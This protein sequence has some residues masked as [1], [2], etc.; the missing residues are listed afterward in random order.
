MKTIAVIGLIFFLLF[1]GAAF[2][3]HAMDEDIVPRKFS[4]V[5]LPC[6]ESNAA[7]LTNEN[8]VNVGSKQ[9]ATFPCLPLM[10]GAKV[11]RKLSYLDIWLHIPDGR[12]KQALAVEVD[13]KL[14]TSRLTGEKMT[15]LNPTI[16]FSLK[17]GPLSAEGSLITYFCSQPQSS[18]VIAD[19]IISKDN[20]GSPA[21][22][23]P[24]RG[25]I[26]VWNSPAIST[27]QKFSVPLTP[28]IRADVQLIATQESYGQSTISALVWF[29]INNQQVHATLLTSG[30]VSNILT[31][32]VSLGHSKILSGATFNYQP[33]TP[34]QDGYVKLNAKMISGV[35]QDTYQ[36]NNIL[37]SWPWAD[38]PMSACM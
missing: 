5:V 4:K 1:S 36:F 27:I 19:V 35:T 25:E 10:Q 21:E 9:T 12:E 23:W 20:D 28:P 34:L 7:K 15:I 32:D 6:L 8:Q 18:R 16:P 17:D 29:Y 30:I 11:Q 33:S 37:A 26:A 38:I 24:F 31:S 13:F 2:E 3:I 22:T 14:N